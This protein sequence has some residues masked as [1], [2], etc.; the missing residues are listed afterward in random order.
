MIGETFPLKCGIDE[1]REFLLASRAF[2]RG[3]IGHWPDESPVALAERKQNGSATMA[4]ALW[5]AWVELFEELSP[6]MA[7]E[8][9]P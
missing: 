2:A 7:G 4:E 6:A 5:L 1:E 9:G 8:A 3:W